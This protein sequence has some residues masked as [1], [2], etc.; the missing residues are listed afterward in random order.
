MTVYDCIRATNER[1]LHDHW[2]EY[3]GAVYAIETNALE[4]E[5]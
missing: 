3:S 1:N 4:V 5:L 2:H